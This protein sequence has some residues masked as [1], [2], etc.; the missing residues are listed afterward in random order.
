M[1]WKKWKPVK[2]INVHVIYNYTVKEKEVYHKYA[3][4]PK[5][6]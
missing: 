6:R 3:L 4:L 1:I 2:N 5:K